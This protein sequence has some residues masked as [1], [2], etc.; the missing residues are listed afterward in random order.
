MQFDIALRA[1][2]RPFILGAAALILPTLGGFPGVVCITP[3]LWLLALMAGS[4]VVRRAA[5]DPLPTAALS[6]LLLGLTCGLLALVIGGLAFEVQPDE[7]TNSLM[8]GA[9]L[10]CGGGLVCALLALAMAAFAGRR[11]RPTS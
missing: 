11:P 1:A 3:V 10:V 8:L 6:G 4:D 2:A 5:P 7:R 9:G